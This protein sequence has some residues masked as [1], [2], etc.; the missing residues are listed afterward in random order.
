VIVLAVLF[1]FAGVMHFVNPSFFVR[2]VPP[3]LAPWA[4]E[5]TYISGV[6]EILGGA[7]DSAISNLGGVWSNG[8]VGGGV[9]SQHLYGF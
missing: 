3:P 2:I 6:F 1:I 5:L 7:V 4:L 8:V 9:S